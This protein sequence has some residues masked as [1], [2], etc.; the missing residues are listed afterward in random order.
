MRST[1]HEIK[2]AKIYGSLV[3]RARPSPCPCSG[4]N[5][6]ALLRAD[7]ALR[8]RACAHVLPGARRQRIRQ[9]KGTLPSPKSYALP[10]HNVQRGKRALV[11]RPG[12]S[13]EKQQ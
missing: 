8:R 10:Y 4:S 12:A 3:H 9:H 13:I 6:G 7:H 2:P 11:K 1:L 5:P